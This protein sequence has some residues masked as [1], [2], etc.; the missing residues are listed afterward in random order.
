MSTFV[1]ATHPRQGNGQFAAKQHAESEVTLTE[2]VSEKDKEWAQIGQLRR[3]SEDF[4][5][6]GE[7]GAGMTALD[8]VKARE[9]LPHLSDD[10]FSKRWP[11]IMH[12]S[13]MIEKYDLD[14][15]GLEDMAY[16]ADQTEHVV[17]IDD[18]RDWDGVDFAAFGRALADE[19]HDRYQNAV[20]SAVQAD[21]QA[22]ADGNTVKVTEPVAATRSAA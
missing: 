1:A 22:A 2:E 12:L 15:G 18:F 8:I 16:H 9:V 14:E 20:R 7:E 10:E 5:Y 19:Y 6:S 11:E 13:R 4:A 21:R 17:D 3:V